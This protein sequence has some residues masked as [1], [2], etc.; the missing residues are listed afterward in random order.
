MTKLNVAMIG[1]QFMG[2]AHSNAWR[3]VRAFF[4]SP[5]HPVMKV[6][7]GRSAEGA[8]RAAERLGWEESSTAWR[9]V[10]ERDDID[11]IDI[12]TPGDLHAE[13]A[14]AAAEAGK[15]VFCEKPLAN[16]VAQAESMLE[17]VRRA[18]VIHMLCHNYRRAPALA[19]AKR[20]IDAGEIGEIRHF[21]GVYLQDWIVDPE[22]PRVWR[23]ER[24]RSGSGALG[25]IASHSLDLARH[26]VGEISEVSGLL[27]TFVEERPLEDGQGR[28]IVDVDDAAMAIIRF[29]GGA[30]GTIEGSRF[31]PG[32]KNHNRFE[33]N[34]ALGSLAWDL[35][36]MNELEVY[37]E[38][39]PESGFRT[40]LATDEA[41]PYV[42]AWWP[43]GHIL[44]Y[45][46][47]FTHTVYDLLRAIGAGV[48]PEPNFE[49]GV[50]NQRVLDAI[51]RSSAT[52]RWEKV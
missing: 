19:L 13:I 44:G 23:L 51:E 1:Y 50:R 14:I 17:A 52:R 36:R 27:E 49:D 2:R 29:E 4:D 43:P 9:E 6:V 45:E 7:C 5:I 46:H 39:G 21:R 33:I 16:T 31:C 40:I 41:H 20:M 38:A 35:E 12:C 26:L 28:G 10:V 47:T 37:V 34:G 30:I 3:Q 22:S 32:R 8:A 11:V 48:V 15:V 24:A 18:G 42:E 25:D